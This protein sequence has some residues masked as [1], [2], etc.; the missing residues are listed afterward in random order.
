VITDNGAFL[1][2]KQFKAL[3]AGTPV[4]EF[5]VLSIVE[6]PGGNVTLADLDRGSGSVQQKGKKFTFDWGPLH[7]EVTIDYELWPPKLTADAHVEI[8]FPIIFQDRR[9]A[10][11][12]AAM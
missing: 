11:R 1:T 4:S 5:E 9:H 6:Q 3:L 8:K 12:Q 10:R 2:D 7:A